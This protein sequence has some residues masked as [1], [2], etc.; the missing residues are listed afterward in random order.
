M[1]LSLF[2]L[3]AA[4]LGS[5]AHAEP[6]DGALRA[7]APSALRVLHR[8]EIQQLSVNGSEVVPEGTAI[9]PVVFAEDKQCVLLLVPFWFHEGG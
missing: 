4:L 8:R 9:V 6:L 2:P 1:L 5:A 7:R 3:L